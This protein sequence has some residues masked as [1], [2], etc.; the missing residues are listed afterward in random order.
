MDHQKQRRWIN[1]VCTYANI[2]ATTKKKEWGWYATGPGIGIQ[3]KQGPHKGRLGNSPAILVTT[4]QP[5]SQ[6]EAM[7]LW[8]RIVYSDDH[9]A[10]WKLGGTITPKMNECQVI[11]VADGNGTLLMM[12]MRSYFQRNLPRTGH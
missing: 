2:T 11:E 3:I 1:L 4:I 5:L 12:N 6:R 8:V 10:N 7:L 9:G